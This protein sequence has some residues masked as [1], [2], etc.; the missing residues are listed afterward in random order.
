M[1]FAE[2]PQVTVET[3]RLRSS[4]TV[5]LF[6]GLGDKLLKKVAREVGWFGFG[7]TNLRAQKLFLRTGHV[8]VHKDQVR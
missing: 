4:E 8:V 6:Q 3:P 2:S 1:S 7:R 5:S